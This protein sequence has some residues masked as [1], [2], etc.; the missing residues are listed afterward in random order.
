MRPDVAFGAAGAGLDVGTD[1]DADVGV[2]ASDGVDKNDG[3]GFSGVTPPEGET[4]SRSDL[5]CRSPRPAGVSMLKSR[6][7]VQSFTSRSISS[8]K[9]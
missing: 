6:A 8:L 4:S 3:T 2:G 1:A 5:Q 9:T 7:A